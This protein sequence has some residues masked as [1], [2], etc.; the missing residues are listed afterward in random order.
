MTMM[1]ALFSH[2]ICQK[3]CGERVSGRQSELL[4]SFGANSLTPDKRRGNGA[5][6]RNVLLGRRVAANPVG[7]DVVA[8]VRVLERL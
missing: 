8:V 5:L 7:I 1:C 6:R 3:L 2:N 4:R